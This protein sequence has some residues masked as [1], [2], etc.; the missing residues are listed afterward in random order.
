MKI[1]ITTA[2]GLEAV[3][4]REL[5]DLGYENFVTDNGRILLEGQPNDIAL[6][7][8]HLRTAGRVLIEV[9]CFVAT[10]FDQLFEGVKA[11]PWGDYLERDAAFI[12]A[13]RNVR[14]TLMSVPDTQAITK[15][16][17]AVKLASKYGISIL[18]E[19]GAKY[20][21]ETW[22]VKDSVSVTM[23][24]SG[25]GLHKRGYRKLSGVSPLR[26]TMAAAL[27]SLS[28]WNKERLLVDPF[29]GSGT[30]LIEASMM[31]LGIAPGL[32]RN[33]D[34]EHF[35]FMQ[36]DIK[37]LKANARETAQENLK[38][39]N[40][41]FKLVGYDI[42][43]KVL[44][45]AR[46]NAKDAGVLDFVDFHQRDFNDFSSN[47]KYGV[48]ITNP[49][50]GVRMLEKDQAE[51]IIKKMGTV[52]STKPDWSVYILS[53]LNGV[54]KLFGKKATKRRKLFNGNI[55]TGYYQ[56]LG[57]RPPKRDSGENNEE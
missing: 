14:S 39:Q 22:V 24:T 29:C 52:F 35:G 4:A 6:F 57:E 43:G 30:I 51:G 27:V 33:F 41:S 10:T 53:S 56:F 1:I 23:D 40:A 50:Y 16:A 34:F 15:K 8:L 42:D 5:K 46:Q 38:N 48:V 26:E 25:E 45:T 19:T 55:Q 47:K 2:F 32:N 49:P 37:R 54:E 12:I 3:T 17:I 21:I 18:P 11:L 36:T 9:G 28:V 13:A 20:K 44:H 7:N 31:A